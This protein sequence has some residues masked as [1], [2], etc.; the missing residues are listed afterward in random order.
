MSADNGI[1]ILVTP[2]FEGAV[3][4]EDMECRVKHLQAVENISWDRSKSRGTDNEDVIIINAREMWNGCKPLTVAEAHTDAF[5]QYEE[6]D[7]CEYGVSTIKVNRVFNSNRSG[8]TSIPLETHSEI[9]PSQD[10]ASQDSEFDAPDLERPADSAPFEDPHP[11]CPLN[12]Y[13][14]GGY[15]KQGSPRLK[16]QSQ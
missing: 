10:M 14:E 16:L 4:Q 5:R 3:S 12:M 13:F 8:L 6:L 15:Y 9:P 2:K 11:I 1:Y 7:I